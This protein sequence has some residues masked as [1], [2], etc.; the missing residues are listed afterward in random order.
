M[1]LADLNFKF[2]DCGIGDLENT[3]KEKI[4]DTFNINDLIIVA[5]TNLK[6]EDFKRLEESIKSK[7]Q[8]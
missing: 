2:D 5:G 1:T 8:R 3:I 7:K 6:I 4:N